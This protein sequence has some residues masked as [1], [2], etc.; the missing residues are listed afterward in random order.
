MQKSRRF[1]LW[2]LLAGL[3]AILPALAAEAGKPLVLFDEGHAQTAGN[4]DW[5]INGGYSDFADVFKAQGCEVRAV[6]RLHWDAIK[7]AD[8]LVLPEPNSVYSPEEE[9]AI[10]EFV[11]NGGGLYAIADHDRSDRNGD[12]IDSVGV[13]NR[14]LPRLGLEIDKRYFTEAPV[15]GKYHDT[16]FTTGVK[17][18]GTWG[19]TT[20]RCLASTAMAHIT[21]S[22]KNGGGAFIASNIVGTRGGR[23]I[24][25]GDSS[26]YDD[27]TGNPSDKLHDGFNNPGYSHARLAQNTVKWLLARAPTSPREHLCHLLA[28]AAAPC[29]PED[30]AAQLHQEETRRTIERL[31]TEEPSLREEARAAVSANPALAGLVVTLNTMDRFDQ[32]HRP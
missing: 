14:F 17:A 3:L 22:T 7:D 25:M 27:G 18:V 12:G 26:P 20:V 28:D 1:A 2:V 13:L 9:T 31:L 19:G 15:A 29:S 21:V 5:V 11:M 4:A 16:P 30:E 23:V 32:L 6:K 8:I 24:A 10:V